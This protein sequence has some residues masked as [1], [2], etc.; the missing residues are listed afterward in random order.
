MA[1]DVALVGTS[2]V[3]Q[4]FSLRFPKACTL[5]A[6]PYLQRLR[7]AN[8]LEKTEFREKA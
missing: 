8:I 5:A 6:G 3:A 7:L 2:G 1:E 4:R